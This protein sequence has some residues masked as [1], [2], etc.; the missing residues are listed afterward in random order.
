MKNIKRIVA[1]L[2]TMLLVVIMSF[3]VE[4]IGDAVPAAARP[5]VRLP[6]LMYHK[7]LKNRNSLGKYTVLPSELEADLIYMK[8]HGYTTVTVE[9]LVAYV[10]NDVSL[11][12][13]PIMLTFDDGFRSYYTYVLPL[14]EKYESK[15]VMSI[16]GE[17]VDKSSEDKN[18]NPYLNWS[19]VEELQAS[20]YVEIQNHSYAMHKLNNRVGCTILD[21]E[22][23]DEYKKV[24][25][26]DVGYL[27]L[28][29]SGKTGY[30]PSAFTYPFGAMCKE[31]K[32]ILREMGFL[33]SL[34]S[35]SGVNILTGDEDDL[36]ELKRINRPSGINHDEFFKMLEEVK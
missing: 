32:K 16:I 10:Y 19:Q 28:L 5:S 1:A 27:Q 20:P 3:N 9:D 33:A 29:I 36:Y 26:N 34:S 12:E 7:V 13:K 17:Y 8:E 14:L 35:T 21:G 6:V 25:V 2:L 31:C 18:L 11:P 24:I 23:Y 4:D 15:A 22:S 30:T